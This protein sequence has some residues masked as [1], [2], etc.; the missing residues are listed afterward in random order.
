MTTQ[1]QGR[2]HPHDK[3][4]WILGVAFTFLIAALGYLL[5]MVPGFDHIGQLACAIIIAVIYR[6]VFGY[7][8]MILNGI[9]F[10][11]KILLR[12]AIILYGLKLN[13]DTVLRDGLGLLLRDAIII[14]IAIGLM[15]WLAK[16]LK[17]DKMIS[18]LLGV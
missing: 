9:T 12:F 2:Q 17:A 18:L 11:T 5:A 15:I 14:I 8:E 4:M 10:S 13:I 7:P 3:W 6:Q 16:V 1:T